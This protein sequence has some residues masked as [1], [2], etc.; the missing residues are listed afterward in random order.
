MHSKRLPCW[1][2]DRLDSMALRALVCEMHRHAAEN[3]TR[4]VPQVAQVMGAQDAVGLCWLQHAKA[5]RASGE[6]YHQ[7]R[8][9]SDVEQLAAHASCRHGA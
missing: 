3:D 7:Q 5:C 2:Q 6:P 9:A 1:C 4:S 8:Y